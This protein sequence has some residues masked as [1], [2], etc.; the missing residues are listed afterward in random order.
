MSD[1]SFLMFVCL[2]DFKV[3]LVVEYYIHPLRLKHS[4]THTQIQPSTETRERERTSILFFLWARFQSSFDSRDLVPLSVPQKRK[5]ENKRLPGCRLFTVCY[6]SISE[7]Q[8]DV[9]QFKGGQ[10]N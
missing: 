3:Q 8:L 6:F 9:G 5:L 1:K 2:W 7:S 10:D 4:H